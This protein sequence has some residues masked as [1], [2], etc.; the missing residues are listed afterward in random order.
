MYIYVYISSTACGTLQRILAQCLD[1]KAYDMFN[2]VSHGIAYVL[3][4]DSGVDVETIGD[5]AKFQVTQSSQQAA[6]SLLA[7]IFFHIGCT[8]NEQTWADGCFTIVLSPLPYR[9]LT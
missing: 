1:V 3:Y 4:P 9:K 8:C 2:I 6:E 7:N 5:V